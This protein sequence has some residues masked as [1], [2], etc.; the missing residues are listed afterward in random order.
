MT[1]TIGQIRALLG[2]LPA[3]QRAQ[4]MAQVNWSSVNF[5]T[6]SEDQAKALLARINVAIAQTNPLKD[7]TDERLATLYTEKTKFTSLWEAAREAYYEYITQYDVSDNV[8]YRQEADE[9]FFNMLLAGEH[10]VAATK[11]ANNAAIQ[12][13]ILF[14]A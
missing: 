13:I 4:V 11:R 9:L 12:N 2:L 1:N 6:M 5:M 14:N 8:K 7:S 3:E 10:M